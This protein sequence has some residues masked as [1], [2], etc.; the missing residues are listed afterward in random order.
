MGNGSRHAEANWRAKWK[1]RENRYVGHQCVF[2]CL[3]TYCLVAALSTAELESGREGLVG[4]RIRVREKEGDV[5]DFVKS[6]ALGFGSSKH[7]VQFDG[8]EG[9][10]HKIY[11]RRISR[12][13]GKDNNG[14]K[15]ETLPS[16]AAIGAPAQITEG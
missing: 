14:E 8:E 10:T 5:L 16:D 11:L 13:S 7:I 2:C 4:T 3:L 12:R 9:I 6:R 1:I 15:Y